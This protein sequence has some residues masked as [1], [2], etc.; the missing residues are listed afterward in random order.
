MKT[1]IW[2][3]DILTGLSVLR[4]IY[5]SVLQFGSR[6][7]VDIIITIGVKKTSLSPASLSCAWWYYTQPKCISPAFTCLLCFVSKE[8]NLSFLKLMQYK[9]TL[10]QWLAA[11]FWF[12]CSFCWMQ[13][14]YDVLYFHQDV[15][16]GKVEFTIDEGFL[17][18]K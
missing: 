12:N 11:E 7:S 4:L 3:R 1:T 14:P 10:L 5:Y 6:L 18:F 15:W 2:N 13:L 9:K 8:N 16:Y 17:F